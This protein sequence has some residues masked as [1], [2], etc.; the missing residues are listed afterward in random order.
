MAFSH[1][2]FAVSHSESGEAT[3]A[4]WRKKARAA[5]TRWPLPS[6]LLIDQALVAG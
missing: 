3:P 6:L 1:G 5:V 2:V 4:M